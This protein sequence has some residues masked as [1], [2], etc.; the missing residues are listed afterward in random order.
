MGDWLPNVNLGTGKRAIAI[1]AGGRQN[2]ALLEDHSLK[3]WGGNVNGE[4]GQ[5]N[6]LNLGTKAAHLGDA[7]PVVPS[8]AAEPSFPSTVGAKTKAPCV[9][10]WTT[11]P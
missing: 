11:K 8:A 6:T 1:A 2:C 10:A 4:L 9:R 5:G 3:C 7:L